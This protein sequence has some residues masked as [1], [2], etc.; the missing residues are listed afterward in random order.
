[1]HLLES[2]R[3]RAWLDRRFP[4]GVVRY[5]DDIGFLSPRL[6]VAHGVQLRPD[7]YELLAERSVQLVSNPSANLRLRSGIAPLAEAVK[8]G[9]RF[10]IGLDG[11]AFDD[12][13]D[14]WR[15]MRLLYFLH[16]GRGLERSFTA[17]DIF[18]AA[19]KTGAS[20]VNA[21]LGEDFT[22]VDYEALIADSVFDDLDEAEVLLNRMS[23]AHAKAVYVAGRPI[24]RDGRLVNVNFE[25]ARKE[26]L[27]QAKA[28]LPRLTIERERCGKLIAATRA[29]YGSWT[30]A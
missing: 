23:A 12:D 21:P 30:N 24:M 20:V 13:Q 19:I 29:Y 14:L 17:T 5:L 25:T 22:V 1:M 2:P 18:D 6:A 8:R 3:Q 27:A 11:S 7:E 26:L 16:G 28:D 15:E 10:G 9:L 4:Q